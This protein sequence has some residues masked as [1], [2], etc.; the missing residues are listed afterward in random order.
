MTNSAA[1]AR[2]PSKHGKRVPS[3]AGSLSLVLME[4]PPGDAVCTL[5]TGQRN[6]RLPDRRQPERNVRYTGAGGD[7]V[8]AVSLVAAFTRLPAPPWL[9]VRGVSP[10]RWRWGAAP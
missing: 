3:R 2:R 5:V 4:M 1:R 8:A 9:V 7:P 10:P 6:R